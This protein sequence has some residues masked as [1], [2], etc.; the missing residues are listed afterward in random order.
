MLEN[1]IYSLN[2]TMPV[3][4]VMVGGYLLKRLKMTNES[5][6]SVANK[7]NFKVTLPALLLKD[8]AGSDITKEFDLNYVLYCAIVTTISFWGIWGLSR[9]FVKEDKIRGAFVQASFRGSIAVLGI[10]LVQNIYGD[11]NSMPMVILGAVPL[12]NIYSVIVLTFESNEP[13]GKTVKDAIWGIAQNPI[14]L[15]ILA[16]IICSLLRTGLGFS[17]PLILSRTVDNF[18]KM[19]TPLALLAL[20]AGFE[21]TKAVKKIKPSLVASATKLL[22]QPLVFLP[23]AIALGYRDA[24]LVALLIMLG[25]PTT[26]STYIMAENMG[27]DGVLTSSIVALTTLLSA[28]TLT[29]FIF[30]LKT[31]GLV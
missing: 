26:P 8:L 29:L 21:G 20:G 11:S 30:I 13:G 1:L 6:V 16:G 10:A 22:I 5:F 18:A 4:L 24:A 31:L 12:Y 28:F 2:A 27:N 3:F 9:L 17:Y 19:A 23:V 15:S 14:I 7:I 25:S